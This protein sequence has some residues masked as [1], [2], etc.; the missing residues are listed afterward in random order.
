MPEGF[1]LNNLYAQYA[2]GALE[3]KKFESLIIED[4]LREHRYYNL[5][6]KEKDTRY[7]FV[8]WIYP[9]LHNAVDN[10]KVSVGATFESYISTLVRWSFREYRARLANRQSVEYAVLTARESPNMYVHGTEPVYC[11]NESAIISE[12][13]IPLKLAKNPRQLLILVLKCYYYVSDDFLERLAPQVGVDKQ[14]LCHMID[15]LRRQRIKRHDYIRIMQERIHSQ[16]FRCIIYENNLRVVQRDTML[17]QKLE[18]QLE[19]AWQRFRTM[20]KRYSNIRTEATNQQI[21][22]LL[23][24]S[25]GTVDANL[26]A[27]K[28]R[29]NKNKNA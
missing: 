11:E 8:S 18:I 29:L 17:S 3:R 5:W 7:D 4:I 25:K 24:V 23:K 21:A 19:K 28:T 20:R 22:D 16:Y 2:Q 15:T 9:R 10:Y 27:L 13:E 1:S 12:D 26:H 14:I 6:E